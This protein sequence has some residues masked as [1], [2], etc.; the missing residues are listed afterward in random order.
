MIELDN[1][2]RIVESQS[3]LPRLESVDLLFADFETTSGDDKL[4]SVNPW[5]SCEAL[6]L[7]LTIDT[8]PGA[9]YV[10]LRH[11]YDWPNVSLDAF[12]AWW[13]DLLG[14]SRRWINHNVKYDAHVSANSLGVVVPETCELFDTVTH[15]KIIDSDRGFKGGYGLDA[16]SLA[17]LGMDISA[18]EEEIKR[19]LA[20]S[21]SSDYGRAACRPMARYSCQDVLTNRPLYK[22]IEQRRPPE[23]DQVAAMET[24][25]TSVLFHLERN[26]MCVDR[27]ELMLRE[28]E[29]SSTMLSHDVEL[30]ELIGRTI[31]PCSPDDVYDV[32]CNQYG[33]PVL[34]WTEEDEDG[35]PAGNPSFNK[36][37][38][39]KYL[40]H[41][42]A[43]HRVVELIAEYRQLST[44]R[45][46]FLQKYQELMGPDSR[47]HSSYN[48]CVRSGRMSCKDPNSQQLDEKTKELIHPPEGWA[49]M[50]ADQSQIEFRTIVSYIN[51]VDCI[52]AYN[53][54]PDTD[55]HEWVAEMCGMKRRPAK[56]MNFMMAFGGGKKK[57]VRTMS[58]DLDVVGGIVGR[59]DQLVA[60][61]VVA[62]SQRQS[63]FDRL[64]VE[65]GEAVYNAYHQ[66]LP[67]LKPTARRASA[68]C[69][70]RGYVFNIY[71]R[72]RHLPQEHSHN[73]FN[74]LC[75]STAADIQKERTVALHRALRG[76]GIE[77]VANVHDETLLQGPIDVVEDRRMR[78]CVAWILEHPVKQLRVPLRVSLGTSRLHWRE[79]CKEPSKGGTA[80]S[81]HYTEEELAWL[82][83][84][85]EKNLFD[86]LRTSRRENM[87][88]RS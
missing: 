12:A 78:T 62:E 86:W 64:A 5:H 81:V 33:L 27:D 29:V 63:A 35:Q 66:A 43:P 55:F 79:A 50:S 21:K 25:L 45:S 70:E 49:F 75:Q 2:G 28:L 1:G 4:S 32:L 36:H 17:W 14:K 60:E 23:C 40:T 74:S 83:S 87:L 10:P 30:C 38:M 8:V 61:G 44:H 24:E 53:E 69:H 19:W 6:G 47:L 76:T 9:W 37:A 34:G 48:Q 16:L 54:N 26:G 7:A 77:M 15:A 20:P 56:T 84:T 22:F 73:A 18:Y 80:V 31:N 85:P 13:R 46:L 88:V 3:E 68:V 52:R 71:G 65:R 57:T 58:V 59:V 41:P 42:Y 67:T 11:R 51:D 82:R 39:K 72:R